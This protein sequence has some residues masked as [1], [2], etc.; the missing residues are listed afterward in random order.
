VCDADLDQSGTVSFG[1]FS[2][3]IAVWSQIV[4]MTDTGP[5][6][7]ADLDASGQV[8]FG[9]FSILISSWMQP[10]GPSCRDLPT[11]CP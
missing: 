1:D 5:I 11:P 9:D 4:P 8:S 10:P 2:A 6:A 7:N 3:L